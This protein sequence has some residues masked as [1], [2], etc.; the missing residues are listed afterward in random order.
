MLQ[1]V[2]YRV[3]R[4]FSTNNQTKTNLA[5]M[6]KHFVISSKIIKNC[7]I[8]PTLFDKPDC[9]QYATNWAKAV[10]IFQTTPDIISSEWR[11]KNPFISR[12]YMG[13]IL[14]FN[15]E[16]LYREI[17]RIYSQ[18]VSKCPCI[19]SLIFRSKDG[20]TPEDPNDRKFL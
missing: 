3:S 12:V 4:S 19:R 16:E 8:R 1:K 15:A 13:S 10:L 17:E 9:K 7:P 18:E 6:T 2:L 14:S 5:K 20:I 11:R